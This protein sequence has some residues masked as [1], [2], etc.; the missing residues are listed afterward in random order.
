LQIITKH[1]KRLANRLRV[2]W[3]LRANLGQPLQP[4]VEIEFRSETSPLFQ[5]HGVQIFR[6]N[7]W[8]QLLFV[9]LVRSPEN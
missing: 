6:E 3:R 8:A 5:R 9:R 1:E 7:Y 2:P 4:L